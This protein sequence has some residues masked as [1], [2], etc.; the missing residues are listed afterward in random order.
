MRIQI[1]W[2]KILIKLKLQLLESR[3]SRN[4]KISPYKRDAIYKNSDCIFHFSNTEGQW[5]ANMPISG[6]C[7]TSIVK[8]RDN[9][10]QEILSRTF[11]SCLSFDIFVCVESMDVKNCII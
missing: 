11:Y 10:K 3:R 2:W 5:K 8:N 4:N 9:I 1:L 6:C 7:F